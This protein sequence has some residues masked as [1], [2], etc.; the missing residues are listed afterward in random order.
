MDDATHILVE[1]EVR[2]WEDATVNGV[3]DEDGALIPGKVGDIWRARIDLANGIIEDWPE[4]TTARI[5]YKV[6]DAGEYW[7]TD[8]AGTKLAKYDSYY[9]PDRFLCHGDQGFGDYIIMKVGP[10]GRI[11]D[12]RRPAIDGD[13]IPMDVPA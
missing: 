6:C 2:Y 12:Y 4:G 5:H 8:R 10:D 7:L 9:V 1:A 11:E 3:E 13:W